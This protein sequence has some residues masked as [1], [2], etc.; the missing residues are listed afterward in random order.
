VLFYLHS[1]A[2]KLEIFYERFE[3]KPFK[4]NV[5]TRAKA[6]HVGDEI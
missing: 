5:S 4:N 3:P 6:A 2:Y 1:T